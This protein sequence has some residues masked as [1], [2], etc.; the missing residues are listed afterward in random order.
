MM[1]MFAIPSISMHSCA[2]LHSYHSILS[3]LISAPQSHIIPHTIYSTFAISAIL[4]SSLLFTP[5]PL[6]SKIGQISIPKMLYNWYHRNS[7]LETVILV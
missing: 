7:L 4:C 5:Y 3:T 2:S 1:T 6:C